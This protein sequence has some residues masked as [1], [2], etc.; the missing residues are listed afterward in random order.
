MG[1]G[2]TSSGRLRSVLGTEYEPWQLQ[3]TLAG[4]VPYQPGW[5]DQAP[6]RPLLSEGVSQYG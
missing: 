6:K 5:R 4:H 3:I 1:P 2:Q